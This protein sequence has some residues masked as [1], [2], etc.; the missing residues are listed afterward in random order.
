MKIKSLTPVMIEAIL[1]TSNPEFARVEFYQE[2]ELIREDPGRV[3]NLSDLLRGTTNLALGNQVINQ[4]RR[5]WKVFRITELDQLGLVE[6]IDIQTILNPLGLKAA[7][8]QI[9]TTDLM[10]LG[11]ETIHY[12]EDGR[13]KLEGFGGLDKDGFVN[14]FPVLDTRKNEYICTDTGQ[15]IFSFNVPILSIPVD[16]D[17]PSD[18]RL[19]DGL[20]FN[21]N[22]QKTIPPLVGQITDT[23]VKRQLTS[24][25]LTGKGANPVLPETQNSEAVTA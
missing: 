25:Y 20:P 9:Q 16:Q 14:L 5:A 1:A 23:E 10:P 2:V 3:T 24:L 22:L 13:I 7:L 12:L 11:N 8:I 21:R 4:K 18:L 17:F 19:S 6:G 15:L